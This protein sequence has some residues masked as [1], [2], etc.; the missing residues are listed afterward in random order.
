MEK[1][2]E[3]IAGAD[4]SAGATKGRRT[5][6]GVIRQTTGDSIEL[7]LMA[8]AATA[9]SANNKTNEDAEKK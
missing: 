8:T 9:A 2:K 3:E 1:S 5:R 7:N 4:G 6:R